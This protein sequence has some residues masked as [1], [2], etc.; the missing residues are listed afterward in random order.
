MGMLVEGKWTDD[1][2]AS[3]GTGGK[4]D[5]LPT[6]FRNFIT[7]DG[8]SGFKA[9]P[10][11]YTIY[12]TKT[13]PWAHRAILF[14]HLKGLNDVIGLH[15]GGN[16]DQ[17][18]KM[19]VDGAHTVPGTETEITYLHNVYTLADPN[20]TGRCTVPTLW[21]AKEKTVVNNESAEIIRMFNSEFNEFARNHYDYY[22]KA[23]RGEIDEIND[24]IYNAINNGV[25]KAGFSSSQEAYEE[26]Y[27]ALFEA[28]EIV[29][30]RLSNQRYLCG[31][32]ITEADWRLFPTLYRFDSVY[33]YAFKC[34]K[35]HLYQYPNMW[36]FVRELYQEPGI[37]DWCFL[38]DAKQ[39]YWSGPK[40]NPLG[41]I[42]KGPDLDFNEAHDRGKYAKEG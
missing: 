19:N 41:T 1:D 22:P 33:H 8:S 11:R 2:G 14:R 12:A 18:Y 42:P 20:Y 7:A 3:R 27:D 13:C 21:D 10:G 34:N 35:K 39:G 15:F 26:A 24:L 23:L 25:Y 9:E 6:H 28:F 37:A 32:T 31:D 4:F 5:H 17:G 30:K 40:I 36:N 38:E 16:G 29:E